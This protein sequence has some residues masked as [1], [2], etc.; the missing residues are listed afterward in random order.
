MH[1]LQPGISV[2]GA[3]AAEHAVVAFLGQLGRVHLGR[4]RD[5]QLDRDVAL[6]LEQLAGGAEVADVGHARADEHLVDL[7]AGH[8]TQQF[9]VVRVVRAAQHRLLDAGSGRSRS[10]RRTRRRASASSSCGLGQPR[11]DGLDAA[12]ERA[13]CRHSRR[14]SCSSSARRC[15][16]RY[17]MIGAWIELDRAAGGR[18]LGAGVAQFER[19]LDL[20]I[21]QAFDL[22]DAAG[23]DVLLALLGHREQALAGS[24]AAESRAPG[25][26]A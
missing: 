25:R 21:G 23:E 19:L 22:E 1:R 4:R 5:P 20:Q 9:G 15:S 26:A 2:R 10:R 17:S 18:A 8:F 14:R 16:F 24:R 11:L 12:L 6:A 13:L 3:G 7:G